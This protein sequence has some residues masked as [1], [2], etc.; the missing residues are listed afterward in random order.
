MADVKM[1][2]IGGVRYRP[3][4]AKALGLVE[5]KAAQ[6]KDKAVRVVKNK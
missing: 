2:V 1:L 4:D 3:E 5:A 6:V